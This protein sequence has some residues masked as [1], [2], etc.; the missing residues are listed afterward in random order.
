MGLQLFYGKGSHFLLWAVSGDARGKRV[1]G[2]PIHLNYCVIYIVCIQFANVLAG[3]GFE[4]YATKYP[5]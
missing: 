1:S 3:R 4:T 5:Q 2:I